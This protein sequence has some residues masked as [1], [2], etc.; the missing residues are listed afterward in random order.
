MPTE[1]PAKALEQTARMECMLYEYDCM[2]THFVLTAGAPAVWLFHVFSVRPYVQYAVL[3][4]YMHATA[5]AALLYEKVEHALWN[6]RE[7]DA[8]LFMYGYI[9][10]V[11]FTPEIIQAY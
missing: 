11:I 8:I 9:V 5:S 2:C 7:F 4:S 6:F 3:Y 10:A 1:Y